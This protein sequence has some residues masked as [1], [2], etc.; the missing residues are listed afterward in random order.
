MLRFRGS[1]SR[2]IDFSFPTRGGAR[3]RIVERPGRWMS[4]H[5][6]AR[7]VAELRQL[8]R[9]NVDGGSLE[10]G[11]LG[12]DDPL[13]RAVITV[14]YAPDGDQPVA[15]NVLCLLDCELHGRPVNV[16]HLG[17]VI[18]DQE[19]ERMG[20]SRVLYALTCFLMLAR[21]RLRPV[22]ISSVTQVPAIYGMVGQSFHRVFPTAR[23]KNRRSFEHVLLARQIMA[24]H[25]HAFG[26]GPEAEFD[27]GRFVI[28]N[29]YTGG[30]ENLKKTFDEAPG[31]RDP[32]VN[33]AC[34]R[35]LD[36]DRGDDFLQI[37]QFTIGSIRKHA[38][39]LRP[40]ISPTALG[41]QFGFLLLES[42]VAPAIQWF[43]ASRQ[44][45]ELRPW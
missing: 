31:H 14:I 15:F 8:V 18:I 29:A 35:E 2:Y 4:D 11:V 39:G 36:Y 9:R 10:Y 45:R 20:F 24:R 22:W 30:S 21:N 37:G 6:L 44:M 28:S 12:G 16:L 25:R 13:D 17:L 26:V 1:R 5:E 3:V 41:L 43:D 23:R 33:E 32:E 34:R 27:E 19:Y 7:L 38:I 40:V 42:L